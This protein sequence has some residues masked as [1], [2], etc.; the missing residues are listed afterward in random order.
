MEESWFQLTG[1]EYTV[2]GMEYAPNPQKRDEGYITWASGGRPSWGIKATVAGPDPIVEIGQRPISEEPMGLVLNLA[3]SES[4][5]A[6]S[7]PTL[8]FPALLRFDYVRVYQKKG[9][10]NV[11]CDPKGK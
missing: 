10:T 2:F 7:V 1:S 9:Q 4:F 5:Q 6:V 11:G 3:I 8:H